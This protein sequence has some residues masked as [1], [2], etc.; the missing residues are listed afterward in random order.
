MGTYSGIRVLGKIKPKYIDNIIKIKE[1]FNSS[2][3]GDYEKIINDNKHLISE[4]ILRNFD[5][6]YNGLIGFP[7]QWKEDI[8]IYKD[9]IE[10]DGRWNFI[11][12][13]KNYD[14]K[15]QSWMKYI[16]EVIFDECNIEYYTEDADISIFY[17]LENKKLVKQN[18]EHHGIDCYYCE[19]GKGY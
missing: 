16:G 1:L 14:C 3:F 13:R 19:L 11:S 5:L 9:V 10:E 8:E 7:H 2:S 17:K 6:G 12:T 18:V 15:I 4:K